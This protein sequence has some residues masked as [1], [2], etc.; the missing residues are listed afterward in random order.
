MVSCTSYHKEQ[1]CVLQIAENH[2]IPKHRLVCEVSTLILGQ[3]QYLLF[4]E[5]SEKK[6]LTVQRVNTD[7]FLLK[8]QSHEMSKKLLKQAQLPDCHRASC[9]H[10]ASPCTGVVN[11]AAGPQ[12]SKQHTSICSI[13][14]QHLLPTYVKKQQLNSTWGSRR[15]GTQLH[16]TS[17]NR[18]F[19][20]KGQASANSCISYTF[21]NSRIIN[22]DAFQLWSHLLKF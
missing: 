16:S 6:I 9:D 19:P 12:G 4:P 21:A 20:R 8:S 1:Q 2:L 13:S 3:T 14:C 5:I 11:Q 15:P 22:H 7:C 17:A 10:T 18:T